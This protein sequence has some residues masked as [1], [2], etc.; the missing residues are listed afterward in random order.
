[1]I[2]GLCGSHSTGKTT[3]LHVMKEKYPELNIV[4]ES[5]RDCPYPLNEKT[6]MQ[7][8]EWIMRAQISKEMSYPLESIVLTDRTTYDQLAYTKYAYDAGNI[9]FDQ[10]DYIVKY[11]TT[12]GL[13]YDFVL[14]IPIEF[15]LVCDGVRSV[16]KEYQKQIDSFIQQAMKSYVGGHRY[17][18]VK[19]SIEERCSKIS[20]VIERLQKEL[21]KD[22]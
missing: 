6:N 20:E 14:Y 3:L 7:S 2:L 1:M 17:V 9:T 22:E 11:L 10:Y 5:A 12:W 8:Q 18:E 21:P 19:G 16:D 15:D 13:L 4:T